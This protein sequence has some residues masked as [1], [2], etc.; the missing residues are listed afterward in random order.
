MKF[1][2]LFIQLP[3]HGGG[4]K[5]GTIITFLEPLKLLIRVALLQRRAVSLLIWPMWLSGQTDAGLKGRLK[6]GPFL[7]PRERSGCVRRILNTVGEEKQVPGGRPTRCQFLRQSLSLTCKIAIFFF[8]SL[9][10]NSLSCI[11]FRSHSR[12]KSVNLATA[13]HGLVSWRLKSG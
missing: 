5:G 2:H 3:R 4:V 1:A 9:Q 10:N 13:D 11:F 12:I 7:S 8:A 6:W